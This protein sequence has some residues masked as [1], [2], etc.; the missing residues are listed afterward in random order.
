M[1]ER[2]KASRAEKIINFVERTGNKL[3]H[4]FILFAI[5]ILVTLFASYVLS[6]AGF[7]ASY[8]DEGRKAGDIAKMVTVKV[9]NLVTFKRMRE[10]FMLHFQH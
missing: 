6:K 9:E 3:P 7:E 8:L 1:V 10:M 2:K 4:P 5:F